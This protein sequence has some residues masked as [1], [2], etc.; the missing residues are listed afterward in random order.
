MQSPSPSHLFPILLFSSDHLSLNPLS[1]AR[2]GDPWKEG[3]CL[4]A[5][6]VSCGS[7]RGWDNSSPGSSCPHLLPQ[8]DNSQFI[9]PAQIN[10]C[11][12]QRFD[13]SFPTQEIHPLRHLAESIALP[14][15]AQSH[16]YQLLTPRPYRPPP[17]PSP[18]AL[19]CGFSLVEW[20]FPHGPLQV[21][22]LQ[23]GAFCE[24]HLP[25][26]LSPIPHFLVSSATAWNSLFIIT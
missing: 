8:E 25:P 24:C 4:F 26:L 13:W 21:P 20:L 5:S 15:A 16:R 2:T 11:N 6:C 7:F 18:D 3:L 9:S 10:P 12:S 1:P 17:I 19:H 22:H 23:R 14:L